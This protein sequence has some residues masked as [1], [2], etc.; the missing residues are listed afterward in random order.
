[1]ELMVVMALIAILV[2]IS[3]GAY[4]RWLGVQQVSNTRTTLNKLTPLIKSQWDVIAE[5][6]AKDFDRG[7]AAPYMQYVTPIA[8]PDFGRQRVV[9]V[10]MRLVQFFPMT[11]DE[12]LNPNKYMLP[13]R[14]VYQQNLKN[15]GV[16]GSNQLTGTFESS[17]L[18]LMALQAGVSGQKLNPGDLGGSSVASFPL[19]GGGQIP[20]LVDS[21]GSPLA[22]FRWP[23]GSPDL[24]PGGSQPGSNND[25]TDPQGYLTATNWQTTGTPT[26]VSI[27]AQAIGY[28]PPPGAGNQPQSYKLAP[29]LV[30]AGPDT[31]LGL[32]PNANPNTTTGDDKDNISSAALPS[33]Q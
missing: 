3:A 11:F 6:A 5:Q 30:S 16:T 19:P 31:K 15:L 9:Y 26:Y 2:A 10:K 12:V 23:T 33:T 8:G 21:W 1:M 4:L 18:L 13:P 25:S 28:T 7:L 22:F 29:L 24:N 17:A 20:A 14:Q 32:D 27:F